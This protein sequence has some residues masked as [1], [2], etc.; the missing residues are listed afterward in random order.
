M[1]IK[2]TKKQPRCSS[3][4]SKVE[5]IGSQQQRLTLPSFLANSDR[6]WLMEPRKV[7][8][9]QEKIYFALQ[10]IMQKNHMDE[11]ALAKVSQASTERLAV[12]VYRR[13]PQAARK[14]KPCIQR[15]LS[16]EFHKIYVFQFPLTESLLPRSWLAESRRCRPCA[17][18]TPRS[19]RLSSSCT[20]RRSTSS[21]RRSTKNSSI[22]TPTRPWPCLSDCRCNTRPQRNKRRRLRQLRPTE[23]KRQWPR[24]AQCHRGNR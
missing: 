15:F 22:P 19:S 5:P 21:S 11:D 2:K 3:C 17:R 9:L 14:H 24:W 23:R 6:P 8:K 4:A 10:H 16:L 12:S 20:P 1:Q 18:S 13:C 7:Q